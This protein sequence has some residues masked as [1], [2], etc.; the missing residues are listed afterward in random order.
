MKLTAAWSAADLGPYS[1]CY[2]LKLL[3]LHDHVANFQVAGWSHLLFIGDQEL[4]AGPASIGLATEDFKDFRNLLLQSRSGRFE[5]GRAIFDLGKSRI[6]VDR[7]GG[8]NI[9]FA[10]VFSFNEA[11]PELVKTLDYYEK[12]LKDI[13]LPTPA[14]AL[15]ASPGGDDYYR[16]AI[17]ANF[18]AI[19]KALIDQNKQELI[20]YCRNICGM[21]H[22]LTPTGDDLIHAAFIVANLCSQKGKLFMDSLRPDVEALS[23]QTGLFGRHML[24]IGRRGLTPEPFAS[25]LEALKLGVRE[26][27]IVNNMIKIGSATGFDLAIGITVAMKEY[28]ITGQMLDK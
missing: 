26:A 8:A 9:T 11:T 12:S 28:F 20:K 16:S 5:D 25:Y 2:A 13:D 22:G 21:G 10:P 14:A 3:S 6:T 27:R 23:A 4:A 15:L 24:E 1:G 17:A 19:I 18:P 7:R